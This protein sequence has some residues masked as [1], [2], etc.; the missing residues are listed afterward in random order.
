MALFTVTMTPKHTSI[1]A[2]VCFCHGYTDN[3]SYFKKI[4]YQRLV[5]Q[6]IAFAGIEY[7]GH[8]KSDGHLALINSWD[9]MIG[10]VSSYFRDIANAK[11]QGIPTFLVG[12]SMGGA[13]AYSIYDRMPD[14]FRGVVFVSPMCKISDEMLPPQWVIDIL[15][16]L[17]AQWPFL[18]YLPIAPARNE[19]KDMTYRV[20]E[21]ADMVYRCPTSF[22]R[23][24][25][26]AT[27]R[28][29]ILV[30]QRISS[31]VRDF[32]APFLVVHGMED[33]VT[34][35]RLSQALFDESKS[36]DKSIMLY[37]GMW[38]SLTSGEP[39][40]NIDQVFNDL[41]QWIL[42]RVDRPK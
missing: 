37:D 1:K 20:R 12:E 34:D 42:A 35:P 8:G 39:D 4:E 2:L 19:L 13:V 18:A 40:E 16:C 27:A 9:R 38:H 29:L 25:R 28:E 32:D 14:L 6:G 36:M 26:L 30:T 3:V 23:N 11:F 24:P 41:T 10:D 31:S 17:I 33:R 5:E 7:E 22:G 15:R 21:K